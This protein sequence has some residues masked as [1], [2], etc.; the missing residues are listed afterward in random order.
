MRI[1]DLL[2]RYGIQP[3]KGLGQNFLTA[4]W[5]Y[6]RII[7]ASDLQSDDAVLEIGPGLGTLTGRLAQAAG[8][9]VA[10]ELD[11]RLLSLLHEV[12][13]AYE[14]VDIVHGDILEHDPAELMCDAEQLESGCCRYKVVANLPY[15]IT[16]RVLRNLL[17]A[18]VRPERLTL[19]VQKEVADRITAEPGEM[20][21]LAVSVQV[22][23]DPR[24]I[25]RV[26]ASAFYPSPNVASAVLSVHTYEKPRISEEMLERFFRVV[27]AAFQ[28]K[29][30]QI[31]NSLSANLAQDKASVLAALEEADIAPER[32]PQTL[33]IDE[34]RRLT[35]ALY[36]IAQ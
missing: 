25:C 24:L 31:H 18:A 14:N 6:D 21:V 23:G 4:D 13:A 2:D 9:V 29:R 17:M 16:S 11:E 30:K 26:P 1:K 10:V 28:Q 12:L 20:S 27:R 7:E 22:F 3:S 15:Y 34:W 5:V 32:R 8:R 33:D 36:P 19:L 35:H